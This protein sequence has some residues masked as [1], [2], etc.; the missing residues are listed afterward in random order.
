MTDYSFIKPKRDFY[1]SFMAP[2]VAR[3]KAEEHHAQQDK[4]RSELEGQ[5]IKNRYEPQKYEEEILGKQIQR[6]LDE[7]TLRHAPREN[8]AEALR[9]DLENQFKMTQNKQQPQEFEMRRR[10]AMMSQALKNVQMQK[11][12]AEIENLNNPKLPDQ[13]KAPG[14]V[15]QLAWAELLD[16]QGKSEDAQLVRDDINKNSTAMQAWRSTPLKEREGMIAKAR[17]MGFD[18]MDAILRLSS[19]ETVDDLGASIGLTPKQV[20]AKGRAYLSGQ[21]A[22]TR[23]M[24]QT[25]AAE[26]S[27]VFQAYALENAAKYTGEGWE[28]TLLRGRSPKQL[29]DKIRGGEPDDP[30]AVGRFVAAYKMRPELAGERGKEI[31]LTGMGV[32]GI[33]H[34]E[35]SLPLDTVPID[36]FLTAYDEI[37]AA[38]ELDKIFNQ[39]GIVARYV[40]TNSEMFSDIG[41]EYAAIA[42]EYGLKTHGKPDKKETAPTDAYTREWELAKKEGMSQEEFDELWEGR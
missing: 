22:L 6:S 3:Q 37:V 17:G 4:Y 33:K 26:T 1:E 16:M 12:E 31:G 15:G 23:M 39:A 10:E 5:S 2:Q 18:E 38:E 7:E 21:A 35:E 25:A 11:Y 40:Y 20:D 14:V 28:K 9:R 19:G 41:D 24:N 36:S 32:E 8:A 13:L 29:F 30:R 34:L 27:K 42:E